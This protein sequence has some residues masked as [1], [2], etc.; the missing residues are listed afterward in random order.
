M[1]RRRVARG[2]YGVMPRMPERFRHAAVIGKFQA[3]GIRPV[4]E[5]LA[6]FLGELLVAVFLALAGLAALHGGRPLA[7]VLKEFEHAAQLAVG[8]NGRRRAFVIAVIEQANDLD[9]EVGGPLQ[10]VDGLFRGLAAANNGDPLAQLAVATR[11]MEKCRA[12]ISIQPASRA[13]GRSY[14][15]VRVSTKPAVPARMVNPVAINVD[16]TGWVSDQMSYAPTPRSASRLE[17]AITMAPKVIIVALSGSSASADWRASAA[18]PMN[19]TTKSEIFST[20]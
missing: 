16:L 7:D 19:N 20:R 3:R 10:D 15:N 12:G 5:E 9:V 8:A 17:N 14:M 6:H 11:E 1:A 2:P 13:A 4:L 18:V